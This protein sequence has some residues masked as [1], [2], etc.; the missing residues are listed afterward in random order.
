MKPSSTVQS[1]AHP[2]FPLLFLSSHSSLSS[3]MPFPHFRSHV[4]RVVF[5]KCPRM[6]P[7]QMSFEVHVKHSGGHLWQ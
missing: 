1:L 7:V 5:K 4:L 2:S 6:H 3:L